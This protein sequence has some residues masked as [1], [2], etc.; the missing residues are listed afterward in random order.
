M[1]IGALGFNV[2]RSVVQRNARAIVRVAPM[3]WASDDCAIVTYIRRVY[4]LC[5]IDNRIIKI[6]ESNGNP[7]ERGSAI[8]PAGVA[9][10]C[11]DESNAARSR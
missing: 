8:D 5:I 7:D 9:R 3:R 1:A 6:A 4:Y 11:R 10:Q 2:N